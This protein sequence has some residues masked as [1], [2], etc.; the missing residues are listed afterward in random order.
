MNSFPPVTTRAS[1]SGPSKEE[2]AHK[3]LPATASCAVRAYVPLSGARTAGGS[4]ALVAMELSRFLRDKKIHGH[5]PKLACFAFRIPRF[6]MPFTHHTYPSRLSFWSTI[7]NGL[8]LLPDSAQ[9]DAASSERVLAKGASAWMDK[10]P[11]KS[12]SSCII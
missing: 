6:L 2:V 10:E 1:A 8:L 5:L 9:R 3:K 12:C 11:A 4:S 7:G